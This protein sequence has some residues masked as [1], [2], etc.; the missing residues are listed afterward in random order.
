VATGSP[1]RSIRLRLAGI[2]RSFPNGHA[3]FFALHDI[4]LEVAERECLVVLG[5]SGSGKTTLLRIVA[6]LERPQSGRVYFDERDVTPEPAERRRAGFVFAEDALFPHMSAYDNIAYGVPR[7]ERERVRAAAERMRVEP[8]LERR[9]EGLSGGERQRVALARA[10]ASQPAILLLDEPLARLDAP[11]RLALRLELMTILRTGGYTSLLVTHDQS[12][13]MALGD[14]IAIMHEGRIEQIGS[15]RDLYERPINVFVAGFVGAPAMSL[16][17]AAALAPPAVGEATTIGLRADAVY[18]DAAGEV[19]GRVD[20]VEDLGAEAFAYVET[21][22]G[23]LVANVTGDLPIV[24]AR[25][26]LRIDRAKM[27]AFD[28]AGRRIEAP[29]HV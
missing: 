19:A 26:R 21:P 29:G 16:V 11:L 6:G 20:A 25:I 27:H 5:P 1:S 23:R 9:V 28:A 2:G 12:E 17:A 14:R 3:P 22:A 7:S 24:G 8:C 18:L 13:A 15:P 10:L 4:S